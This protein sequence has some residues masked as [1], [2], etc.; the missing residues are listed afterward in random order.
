MPIAL[1]LAYAACHN[2]AIYLMQQLSHG[3]RA[4]IINADMLNGFLVVAAKRT[5]IEHLIAADN[6]G[7][8]DSVKE[9]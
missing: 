7:E 2:E 8:L 4:Y 3:T 1:I 9:W 6:K 5:L